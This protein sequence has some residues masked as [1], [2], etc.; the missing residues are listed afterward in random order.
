[1][2][3]H[4]ASIRPL[5][6]KIWVTGQVLPG[7]IDDLREAGFT[8]LVNHRPDGEE[9]GQPDSAEL[10]RIAAAA[11]LSVVTAPVRGLPDADAVAATRAALDSL[12]PNGKA[13]MFCRSGMRSAA[14]WAMAERLAGAEPEALK[15]AALSAGYDLSRLPL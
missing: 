11:G 12:G 1:M 4:S 15:E 8:C 14:A 10:S 5:S 13:L 2:L 7:Q 3:P 6:D 9:P